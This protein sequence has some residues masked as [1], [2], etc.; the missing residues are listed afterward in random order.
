MHPTSTTS[1]FSLSSLLLFECFKL[2]AG[3]D[4]GVSVGVGVGVA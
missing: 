4:T 3:D 1:L 2:D